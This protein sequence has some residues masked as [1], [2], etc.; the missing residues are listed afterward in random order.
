MAGKYQ[1]NK[2]PSVNYRSGLHAALE[3][4]LGGKSTKEIRAAIFAKLDDH[5]KEISETKTPA[6]SVVKKK[7]A[8]KKP[9]K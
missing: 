3:A 8:P 5:R 6:L 7:T 1:P 9:G 2:S 4:T